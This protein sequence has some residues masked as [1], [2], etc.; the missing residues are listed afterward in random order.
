M[1]GWLRAAAAWASAWKRRRNVGSWAS[2]GCSTFTATRRRSWTSSARYTWAEAPTPTGAVSL[3][4]PASTR[5]MSSLTGERATDRMVPSRHLAVRG[6]A[7]AGDRRRPAE[8]RTGRGG[9][10]NGAMPRSLRR[11]AAGWRAG[12]RA[13]SGWRCSSWPASWRATATSRWSA[14]RRWRPIFP[15]TGPRSWPRTGSGADLQVGYSGRADDQRHDRSPPTS[16]NRTT[17]STSWCSGPA[18]ARSSPAAPEPQL[19]RDHVL[20]HP[21]RPRQRRAT[22]AL[23]LRRALSSLRPSA[24]Q[25]VGASAP[26]GPSPVGPSSPAGD[27]GPAPGSRPSRAAARSRPRR[28]WARP[29]RWPWSAWTRPARRPPPRAVVF[30]DTEPGDLPPRALI[31]LLGL[32]PAA[33]LERAGHHHRRARPAPGARRAASGPR[34]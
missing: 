20:E 27:A 10:S 3:Y 18:R 13:W 14:S 28:G 31:G 29:A 22:P 16:S 1:L 4:R 5:P 34:G 12:A 8:H 24:L 2:A 33:A 9:C 25:P 23:V 32:L 30:F 26:V 21:G 19:R 11:L 6:S 7:T 17:A 15:S